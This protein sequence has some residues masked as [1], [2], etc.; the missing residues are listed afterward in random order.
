[1]LLNPRLP[2]GS[3]PS[4]SRTARKKEERVVNTFSG[5]KEL[6]RLPLYDDLDFEADMNRQFG[7]S[8]KVDALLKDKFNVLSRASQQP[9]RRGS[10]TVR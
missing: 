8:D 6:F 5:K 9:K 3:K 10:Q 1:V 4:S 7:R 2:I